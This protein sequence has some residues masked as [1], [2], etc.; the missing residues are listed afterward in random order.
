MKYFLSI[1]L[2]CNLLLICPEAKGQGIAVV[3]DPDSY[4]EAKEEITLYRNSLNADGLKSYL[5]IDHWH[6]PDSIKA[7]LI[8]LYKQK[9]NP[10]EGA[11]FIGDIPIPMVRDAQ[12]LTSAFKMDQDGYEWNESSVPSDRFY[13]DFDLQFSFLKQDSA[14]SN[15]FYY[16]LLPGPVQKI[17]PEIYTGRI[18]PFESPDK[19]DDL[20]KYLR[21]V[22]RFKQQQHQVNQL[23]FFAGHG[24]NSDDITA[25][26]DEK[27]AFFEQFPWFKTQQN[28]IEYIDHSMEIPIKERLLSELQRQDLDIAVLH[29]HG[30]DDTQYLNGTPEV[31]GIARQIDGIKYYLRS[32]LRTSD[33]TTALI[34]KYTEKYGVPKEWFNGTFS[35]DVSENDSLFDLSLNIHLPDVQ[36]IKQQ[37]PFLIL[38]ACFNGSFHLNKYIAGAYLFNE[39][40]TL[41]VQANS[42]NS[43]QDKWADEFIGLLGLG[44][45][46]GQWNRLNCYLETHIIGDP[47]LH[48]TT[49]NP[50]IDLSSIFTKKQNN[51][52][53]WEKQLSSR[54]PEMQTLALRMLYE[55]GYGQ[56]SGL[57]LKTYNESPNGIVR[58]ECLKLLTAY[59]D[60][61]FIE[62]LSLATNDSYEMARRQAMYL[63][64]K[65]GDARLIP[66]LISVAIK[67]NAAKRVDFCTKQSLQL[68]KEEDLLKAFDEIYGQ[69]QHFTQADSTR[70]QLRE[71]ISYNSN[72][73][74]K[75]FEKLFLPETPTKKK[76]FPIGI[77]RNCNYHPDVIRFCEW[78]PEEQDEDVKI[79][80]L[81]ALGWFN[82]SC[83]KNHIIATCRQMINN[84]NESGAVRN[85]AL[86]TLNRLEYQWWR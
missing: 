27:T 37:V 65:S 36:R 74:G 14:H 58:M 40:N 28:A 44:L 82:V 16:S 29:H 4:N 30:M 34:A 78:L 26:M 52:K 21:K 73:W 2:Y 67:N 63:I 8:R 22:T 9:E 3:V 53:F 60:D 25:R 85:E 32:K 79:L 72:K 23:L 75:Y 61:N 68:F 55:N 5:L 66:S 51:K 38:D 12:H 77:L 49:K 20:K 18:K 15:Y 41:A 64:G 39:G 24:Y 13:D 56:L 47:T 62:C 7:N 46:A 76:K 50:E 71:S 10:I 33:D 70:N 17:K 54:Y 48:F 19:Y 86:K 83:E 69:E 59:N 43:L 42:V 57:L 31:S 35:P 45:R 11:V 1:M 81:E 84:K 80:M 6:N